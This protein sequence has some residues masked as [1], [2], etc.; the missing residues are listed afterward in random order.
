[1]S[2]EETPRIKWRHA[3]VRDDYNTDPELWIYD[4]DT[5]AKDYMGEFAIRWYDLSGPT[6]QPL[7]AKLEVFEDSWKLLNHLNKLGPFLEKMAALH[8]TKPTP[9]QVGKVL[10]DLGIYEE[11]S[12]RLPMEIECGKCH[13]RGKITI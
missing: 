12:T 1:M 4:T 6:G 3:H 13:G 5:N 7:F 2:D 11:K 10:T 9:D 8:G